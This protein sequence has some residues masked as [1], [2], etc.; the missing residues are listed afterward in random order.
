MSRVDEALRRAEKG[1]G[2][3]E[4]GQKLHRQNAAGAPPAVAVEDYPAEG[5]LPRVE[6]TEERRELPKRSGPV[7]RTH[8]TPMLAFD[9]TTEAKLVTDPATANA[10]V[11]QYRRLATILFQLQAERGIKTVMIS[12]ALP[13]EGKT[14]TATNL[15]LTLAES[16]K[17]RVLLIDGDL[18]RPSLHEVFGIPNTSGLADGL[19]AETSQLPLIRVTS[20]LTVLPAGPLDSNP[21]A[22]LTSDRL[23]AVLREARERFDWVILDSPPVGL[24]S[25]ASLLAGLVDGVI[26]VVGA[27]ATGYQLVLK[28]ISDLGRDRII[29]AVLNRV[30]EEN[31]GPSQYYRHYYREE[32]QHVTPS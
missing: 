2:P 15:A 26:L 23:P 32:G 17:R 20:L 25:D 11:E 30:E 5:R 18:R 24:L 6:R 27:G 7:S 1:P 19:R 28:A 8:D 12:S 21:M 29:G 22:G 13:R 10:S 9:E 14:L 4:A 3:V 16:H 31:V